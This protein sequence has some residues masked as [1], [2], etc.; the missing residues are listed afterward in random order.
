MDLGADRPNDA[1]GVRARNVKWMFVTVE[2]RERNA[3]TS[4]Y[5]VVIDT[6]GHDVNQHFI[7]GDRPG[8]NDLALHRLLR[9]AV[10]LF[11]NCPRVHVCRHVTERRNLADVVKVLER[12]GRRFDLRD[13]HHSLR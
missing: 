1:G 4:P 7:L 3:E 5:T 6:A 9:R 2:W 13:G 10:T 12:R 8:W 11:S